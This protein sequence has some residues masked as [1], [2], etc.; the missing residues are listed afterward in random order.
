MT[1]SDDIARVLEMLV[2]Q[3]AAGAQGGLSARHLSDRTGIPARRLDKVIRMLERVGYVQT[4]HFDRVTLITPTA[5]ARE[6]VLDRPSEVG[7][8]KPSPRKVRLFQIAGAVFLAALISFFWWWFDLLPPTDGATEAASKPTSTLGAVSIS[9]LSTQAAPS[10]TA[11]IKNTVTPTPP[12]TGTSTPVPSP[13]P[14]ATQPNPTTVFTPV[15]EP[16]TPTPPA[17]VPTPVPLVEQSQDAVNILLMGSDT[18]TGNWRTDTLIVASVHPEP[19]AVSLLSIPRDLYVYVPGWQMGRINTVDYRGERMGY[20]GGGPG[21]LKS[22]IEYNLGIPIDFYARVNFDGFVEILDILGGVDVVVDCALHDTF[23]D[24]DAPGGKSDIDLL[25]GVHHLDAKR[26]LWYARSRWN[27]NDF[28]RGRRQQRVLRSAFQ[29]IRQLGLLTQVPELWDQMLGALQTDL[30]LDTALW[31]ASIGSRLGSETAVKSRFIDG[32]VIREWTTASGAAVLLPV[33]ER[34]R[35]LVTEALAPS[36]AA[37]ARQAQAQVEVFNATGR[38]DW[39]IL[40]ADRLLWEGFEVTNIGEVD[41]TRY[42]QTMILDLSEEEKGSPVAYLARVLRVTDQN[43]HKSEA[44]LELSLPPVNEGTEFRVIVG[45]DY[46]P[47]YKSYWWAL[48]SSSQ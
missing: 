18:T 24:P 19:P 33:Y 13:L 27:T 26:A 15:P 30:P 41:D 34:I 29:Q 6:A 25:P 1:I 48:H 39:G 37:R 9:P 45:Q 47:C 12:P 16:A 43:I 17:N 2:A 20:P 3:P 40:V 44:L 10:P 31:L 35:P 14:Q 22:T 21:L 23:P 7:H 5:L 32:T 42:P 36:D 8:R 4:Q 38:A 46:L 11:S 28:D